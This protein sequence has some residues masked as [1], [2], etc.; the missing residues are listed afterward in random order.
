MNIIMIIIL[1]M[2][3]STT[4]QGTA[5]NHVCLLNISLGMRIPYPIILLKTAWYTTD[6]LDGYAPTLELH[7]I[8]NAAGGLHTCC[9]MIYIPLV[10]YRHSYLSECVFTPAVYLA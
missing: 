3:Y 7:V 8:T 9:D 10:F 2:N 5:I 6:T 4:V 1:L